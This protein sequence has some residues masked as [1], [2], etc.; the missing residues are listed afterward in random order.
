MEPN[1]TLRNPYLY[2]QNGRRIIMTSR[3][4]RFHPAA[5]KLLEQ[6]TLIFKFQESLL[7]QRIFYYEL[8]KTFLQSK[9]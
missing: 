4:A 5:K 7:L 9:W 2:K 1:G 3:A 8:R 6:L